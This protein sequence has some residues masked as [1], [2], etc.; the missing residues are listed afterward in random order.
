MHTRL[1][2]CYFIKTYMFQTP[3]VL[4][5]PLTTKSRKNC[6]APRMNNA[7][8]F[9]FLE[10]KTSKYCSTKGFTMPSAGRP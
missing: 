1:E 6:F 8:N 3:E 10:V 9:F 2:I 4:L 5:F 7:R